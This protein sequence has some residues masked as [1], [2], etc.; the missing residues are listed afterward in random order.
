MK[1]NEGGE[2]GRELP[3]PIKLSPFVL[4]LRSCS[5][6]GKRRRGERKSIS[7]QSPLSRCT[8]RERDKEEPTFPLFLSSSPGKKRRK[9]GGVLLS[10]ISQRRKRGG[11]LHQS[12]SKREGKGVGLFGC[13]VS[14]QKRGRGRKGGD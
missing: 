2:K 14:S 11:P 8:G 6:I 1:S 5:E 9:K 3:L 13:H 4:S 7:F 12:L 10:P